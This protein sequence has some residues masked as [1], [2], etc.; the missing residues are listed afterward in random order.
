MRSETEMNSGSEREGMRVFDSS[1]IG[2]L[3]MRRR[4]RKLQPK[5]KHPYIVISI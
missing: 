1:F 4:I 2:G 5:H 3:M